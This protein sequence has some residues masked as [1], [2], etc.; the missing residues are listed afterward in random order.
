M[1]VELKLPAWP[2]AGLTPEQVAYLTETAT[3][4]ALA[5]G[6]VYRP[7]LPPGAAA[8][9]VDLASVIHAPFTLLPSPFPRAL[10]SKAQRL[11]PV[12]NELYA[13]VAVDDAFLRT[14]F[15]DQH[16]IDVDQ[17]QHRLWQVYEAARGDGLAQHLQLGLFRSD[18]LL[19]DKSGILGIKQVEFN[20]ISSSFGPLCAQVT[21][22]H[23]YL[24]GLTRNYFGTLAPPASHGSEAGEAIPTNEALDTLAAGIASAH[25]AYVQ[26]N[27]PKYQKVPRDP[28]VLFVVQPG[29]RNAFDQRALEYAL[30]DRHG[31]KAIRLTLSEL[32]GSSPSTHDAATL[33]LPNK[34]LFVTPPWAIG[35]V[36]KDAE[37]VEVSVVYFRAGYTPTDYEGPG[38]D[39][40]WDVRLL[41]ERSRAI[42]CPSVALQLAGAKKVQQVLA[43]PGVME[44]FLLD[45]AQAQE[46]SQAWEASTL[47]DIRSTWTELYTLDPT[48]EDGKKAYQLALSEPDR[49]VLKPQREGGGNNIYKSD[50]PPALKAMEERDQANAGSSGPSEREGYILMS[51]IR[52]PE[53]VGNLL[54]KA[55]AGSAGAALAPDVVSELGIY[56]TSLF[57]Q[58]EDGTF[59]MADN[60]SG[61]H[62]LRTKGR[63]SNEGGVAVGFSV[64]DSPYLL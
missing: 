37:Q 32:A 36:G 23:R 44:K 54:V 59:V 47:A 29:E 11:Q 53:N 28:V 16:V 13:R 12:L 27:L 49:F 38:N 3:D 31:V 22:L 50:I 45:E 10:F 34:E 39:K 60:S 18:Y 55:G 61:G 33:R 1:A 8:E 58:R 2:P 63:D 43:Q 30:A 19:D 35:T 40:S 25:D 17:F 46:G 21:H 9:A 14:I 4:Y 7:P 6:L 51:L 15:V 5:H 42:K 48:S 24:A 56:G 20:T 41:L 26:H 64:I 52:P 57:G 62:L